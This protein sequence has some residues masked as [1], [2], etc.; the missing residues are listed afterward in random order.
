MPDLEAQIAGWRASLERTVADAETIRELEAHLRDHIDALVR[1]GVPA[2]AAFEQATRRLGQPQA[3]AREF[4]RGRS[5]WRPESPAEWIL[6]LLALNV[7]LVTALLAASYA[8]GLM[9]VLLA[10]HVFAVAVGYLSTVASGLIGACALVTAWRRPLMEHERDKLRRI[11][12]RLTATS[13][14]CL[15]IGIALG[16]FWA[17][18]NLGHAWAW[19]PLETGAAFVLLSSLLLLLAQLRPVSDF[20]RYWLAVIGGIILA[21]GWVGANALTNVVP[22]AW[23]CGAFALSQIAV[24]LVRPAARRPAAE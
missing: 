9:S 2:A 13:I 19:T 15:P 23:L 14:G 17:A 3:I 5:R 24:L 1:S 7:A 4:S 11:L 20:A 18:Q 21:I 6:V 10:T 22:I 12:F 16:M 8:G